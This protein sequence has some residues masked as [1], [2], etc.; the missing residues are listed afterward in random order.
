MDRTTPAV[1]GDTVTDDWARW[2]LTPG[3]I[4]S[5]GNT[6][7]PETLPHRGKEGVVVKIQIDLRLTGITAKGG[8]KSAFVDNNYTFDGMSAA[9]VPSVVKDYGLTSLHYWLEAWTVLRIAQPYPD[10]FGVSGH[11]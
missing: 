3:R 8:A 6:G 7:V 1:S 4:G 10:I 9:L 11:R 5:P 2:Y